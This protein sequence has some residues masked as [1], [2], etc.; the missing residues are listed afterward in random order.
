[1]KFLGQ[2]WFLLALVICLAVGTRYSSTLGEVTEW[3]TVQQ[4][5]VACVMFMMAWPLTATTIAQTFRRPGPTLLASALNLIAVPILAK[6][7]SWLFSY[8]MGAGFIV[9][10]A[11]PSTLASAAVWTRRAGGNDA[12]AIMT[13]I[14]TNGLCFLVTPLWVVVWLGVETQGISF[15]AMV[16]QLAVLVVLPMALAQA[17]R[18]YSPVATWATNQKPML[19]QLA[20][21]GILWIVLVGSVKMGL[22]MEG[23]ESIAWPQIASVIFGAIFLH[24]GVLVLG[25]RM[26]RWM[27]YSRAD[28]IAV[29]FSGS[30]KTLMVGLV[31]CLQLG[32]SLLPM[33]IYHALQLVADTPVADYFRRRQE[34]ESAAPTA[35]N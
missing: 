13:T 28:Q 35:G 34:A 8:E 1:M 4:V 2:I 30:Q 29:A 12:I 33:V 25:L 14:L 10:A 20:Q 23:E 6:P 22:K 15:F 5:V 11:V 9:M 7:I 17:A 19:S 16:H 21:C 31:I 26:A 18:A 24:F 3:K 27:G 32:V